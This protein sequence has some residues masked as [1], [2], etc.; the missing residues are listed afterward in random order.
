[1]SAM[2]MPSIEAPQ[3]REERKK[4]K[5][6]LVEHAP[7]KEVI[8]VSAEQVESEP[9]A[10]EQSIEVVPPMDPKQ[11]ERMKVE[12]ALR[13]LAEKRNGHESD[14]AAKMLEMKGLVE[15]MEASQGVLPKEKAEKLAQLR[16]EI[17]EAQGQL[18]LNGRVE[19]HLLGTGEALK[20]E[21]APTP[22]LVHEA[23][24]DGPVYEPPKP[25]ATKTGKGLANI[26]KA[27]AMGVGV[28]AF[29]AGGVVKKFFSHLYRFIMNPSKYLKE[30]DAK[31]DQ[32]SNPTPKRKGGPDA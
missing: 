18:V 10:A 2:R 28:G 29:G 8:D 12:A 20:A 4:H 16:D 19:A 7:V 24:N 22:V 11:K 17:E 26:G 15:E 21:T 3:P 31:I 32:L 25:K 23:K 1:M 5:L 30:M 27:A 9:V 6:R 14:L 13:D